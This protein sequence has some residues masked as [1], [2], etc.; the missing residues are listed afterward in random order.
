MIIEKAEL[1]KSKDNFLHNLRSNTSSLHTQLEQLQVSQK[2]TQ[3]DL[4]IEEYIHYLKLM[5]P[6]IQYSENIIF[7][8]VANVID[9]INERKKFHLIQ[10][11]LAYFKASSS[12]E[13]KF[14]INNFKADTAFALGVMYVIEG[15]TLGGRVILKNVEKIL[16]LNEHTGAS[17]FAGYNLKTGP[18]WKHFLNMLAAYQLKNNCEQEIIAGAN[19][20]FTGIYNFMQ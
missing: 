9:D 5:Q 20:A 1:H 7:P 13:K 2:L 6:V 11:D 18:L 17:Y 10:Q 12:T 15:S 16:G 19:A 4:C 3:D 14:N 8:V